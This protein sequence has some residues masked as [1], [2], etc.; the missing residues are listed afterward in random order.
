[1]A[2]ENV[3]FND[4]SSDVTLADDVAPY[5]ANGLPTIDIKYGGQWGALP[6]IGGVADEKPIHEWMHE[7]SYMPRDVI[8]IVIQLPRMFDLLPNSTDWKAGIKAF[9]ETHSKKIEGLNSSLTVE[10]S[11]RELGLSG[12]NFR[13]VTDVKR[14][15]TSV[16]HTV[17]ERVG[18]PFEILLDV[19]IRYGLLDPD[20]KAPL[21]TRIANSDLLPKAWTAD[22][23]TMTVLY[24]E[25]D[26]LLRKPVRA[27][28]VSNLFPDANPDIL[29]SKDK[30]AGRAG[31]E[32]SITLGGFSIPSTNRI[33]KSLA[34]TVM[35][36]LELYTLDP[37]EILIP[38]N[39]VDSSVA[40]IADTPIYYEGVNSGTSVTATP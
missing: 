26:V 6:R 28:L 32:M 29:G 17:D 27:W 35:S 2:T 36:N 23:S 18:N 1:M 3:R 21:I 5:S 14:E 12:A 30:T 37:E 13:E 19:W 4:L 31:K 34:E 39:S 8:P 11:E 9:V 7:Q 22:W 38:A 40:T 15:A 33:V 25:P 24:I 10:T 20:L 16:V